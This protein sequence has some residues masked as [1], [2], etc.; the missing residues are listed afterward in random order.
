MGKLAIDVD[1]VSFQIPHVVAGQTIAGHAL[2]A[3]AATPCE[4]QAGRVVCRGVPARNG[5]VVHGRTD[6]T[7]EL[8]E[9]GGLG[10]EVAAGVDPLERGSPRGLDAELAGPEGHVHVVD[11]ADGE[12]VGTR[13]LVGGAKEVGLHVTALELESDIQAQ[14][15]AL[16]VAEVEVRDVAVRQLSPQDLPAQHAGVGDVTGAADVEAEAGQVLRPV[17]V[18]VVLADVDQVVHPVGAEGT[19]DQLGVA[20]VVDDPEVVQRHPGEG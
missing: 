2:R 14:G 1:L 12:G 5:P 16:V 19:Q 18:R 20:G 17:G 9:G 3:E 7:V 13:G 10:G 6:S 11:Q 15:I 8:G 4:E